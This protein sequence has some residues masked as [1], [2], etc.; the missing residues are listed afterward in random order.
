[1]HWLQKAADQDYPPAQVRLA[2]AYTL[3]R[4]VPKNFALAH[5]WLSI[6]AINGDTDAEE[7]RRSLERT[8]TRK[9]MDE[10]IR[11]VEEYQAKRRSP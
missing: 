9:Q 10:S 5:F 4:G 2:R 3:G 1:M 7:S 8:M 11:R 6:A